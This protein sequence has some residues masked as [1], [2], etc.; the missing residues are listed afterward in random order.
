MSA[1]IVVAGVASLYA[2]VGVNGFPLGYASTSAPR[3]MEFGVSGTATHVARVQRSLGDGVRL[4]CPVGG[5]VAGAVI[6][7]EL[8]RLG[9]DGPGVV[10]SPESSLG[11][12]LVGP[13]GKRM[14]MPHVDPVDRFPYPFDVLREQAR[15]A[16]LLVL[17]NAR[18]VR[19]LV[20]AAARLGP[21]IAV[22]VH[23][24]AGLGDDY[25]RPWLDRA[26]IVFCSDERLGD[27]LAWL[28]AMFARYP[29]CR[30]AGV[31]LGARGALVGLRDGRLVEVGAVTP[32]PPVNTSGAGDALFATFVSTLLRLGDPVAA[33]QAGVLHAG[34]KIG[35]RLPAAVSLD[36]AELDAL[37]RASP[38]PT[39]V[40]RWDR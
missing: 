5:G 21:P 22:D 33:L 3:W 23:R 24:L 39:A 18:F 27:P 30:V 17:T 40:R 1:R 4:C 15:D 11:L 16:D 6:R 13:D 26:E 34:W 29:R 31:G 14:G 28:P 38:P 35:H 12:V 8:C 20:A 32:R 9:L 25:D 19:P 2:S 36:A 10:A 37:R 7:N